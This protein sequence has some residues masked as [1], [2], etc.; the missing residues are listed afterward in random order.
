MLM[1]S[2]F[3]VGLI[4][5]GIGNGSYLIQI[6]NFVILTSMISAAN[7]N[8]Y[9]GS[10]CLISMIE[11]GYFWRVFGKTIM[12]SG[13]P[14][15]AILLTSFIGLVIA[16]L[17]N[18]K[19]AGIFLTLLI[20]LSATSGLLMWLF[21]L[22]SYLR[23]RKA[24]E[25]NNINHGD[26]VYTSLFCCFPM[27]QSS[28]ISIVSIVGIILSNGIVNIWQFSW[29]SFASCYLTLIVVVVGVLYFSFKWDEPVLRSVDEIDIFT[30]QSS[31]A[32]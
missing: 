4:N 7:S 9:F 31:N 22:I 12:N 24:L 30:N 32:F 28:W 23:F 1:S 20:N 6:V 3:V 8:I 17:S 5:C 21:I 2:P 13:V 16:L 15:Y 11:E 25:Y 14:V 29:D 10:R 27:K 19:S 18:F 26:L